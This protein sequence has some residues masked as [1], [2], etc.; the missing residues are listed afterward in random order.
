VHAILVVR[1]V[2]TQV[3]FPAADCHAGLP[4]PEA[5]GGDLGYTHTGPA[6][7]GGCSLCMTEKSH[8]KLCG[9]VAQLQEYR[10]CASLLVRSQHVAH[11]RAMALFHNIH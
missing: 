3:V 7:D 2:A 4:A 10:P 11:D 6:A 1:P 9:M 8:V 5:T